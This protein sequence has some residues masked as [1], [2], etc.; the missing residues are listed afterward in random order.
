MPK[1]R[2]R[3]LRQLRFVVHGEVFISFEATSPLL[4]LFTDLPTDVFRCEDITGFVPFSS[5]ARRHGTGPTAKATFYLSGFSGGD[6]FAA[7][8]RGCA[9]P[10][11]RVRD[12]LYIPER[13]SGGGIIF[14]QPFSGAPDGFRWK[15]HRIHECSIVYLLHDIL[16]SRILQRL[17]RFRLQLRPEIEP[18]FTAYP[19]RWFPVLRINV[20]QRNVAGLFPQ[21]LQRCTCKVKRSINRFAG[22]TDNAGSNNVRCGVNEV[23]RAC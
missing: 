16:V 12:G 11:S 22:K 14:T 19:V 15:R 18:G 23:H 8:S 1:L 6:G 2:A 13:G 17:F 9:N 21:F 20:A 4:D 10:E 7:E 3:I 5:D